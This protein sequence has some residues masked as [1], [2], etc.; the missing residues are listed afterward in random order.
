MLLVGN[1]LTAEVL[2]HSRLSRSDNA[3]S[4]HTEVTASATSVSCFW[5]DAMSTQ[6]NCWSSD[7]LFMTIRTAFLNASIL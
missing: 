3:A 1:R 7:D 5:T 6:S 2:A 4:G